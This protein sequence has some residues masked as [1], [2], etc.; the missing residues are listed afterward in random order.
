M[1]NQPKLH[2]PQEPHRPFEEARLELARLRVQGEQSLPEIARQV[3]ELS[4]RTLRVDRVGVWALVS[5]NTCL[6]CYDLYEV[7]KDQ[8]SQGAM[9]NAQDFPTYFSA[10]QHRRDI[11]ADLA[12][13][14]P[15]T[16]ELGEA[17]LKPLGIVSLL[18]APV[19]RGGQVIGVICHEQVTT[20]RRWSAEERDFATAVA[21]ICALSIETARRQ[22]AESA[23]QVHQAYLAEREKD[24]A[25]GR[26]AAGV[27]HDFKNLLGGIIGHAELIL[28]TE[29]ISA[30]TRASASVI[31]EV[32]RRGVEL[33]RN[34]TEYGKRSPQSTRVTNVADTLTRL[35][36]V[37]QAAV[38]SS[39]TIELTCAST[40]CV[41][42]D[43][44]QLER[45]MLNL[46]INAREAMPAGG[47]IQVRLSHS[48]PG[49]YAVIEVRDS[50]VGMDAL[51]RAR[52]FEPFFTTKQG[53]GGTGLGLAIVHQIVTRC[54]G[55]IR[56]D[57]E[58]G[59]GTTFRVYL[60]Q[61][62]GAPEQVP[63]S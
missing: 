6:R 15:L 44:C 43:P 62:A 48:M 22:D 32:G 20:P 40:G 11:P 33:V 5:D 36:G 57:S 35:A 3:T 27:A 18:D 21:D 29:G 38:G 28:Y 12:E 26:L 55:F 4:A 7:A 24:E 61:V 39:H 19:Y 9:L 51:T 23:V 10:L 42:I 54:G 34:L 30:E 31:A 13:T 17:Y 53:Q 50:G 60:P 59:K 16:Q 41:L 25:L 45:V 56:V 2:W 46:V 58:V 52:I 49:A 37:L 14:D 63:A 8:H 47:K 1:S